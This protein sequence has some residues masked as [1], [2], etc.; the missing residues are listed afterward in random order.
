MS[1][2][3]DPKWTTDVILPQAELFA[4]PDCGRVAT[5]A[6]DVMECLLSPTYYEARHIPEKLIFTCDNPACPRCDEVF[7]FSLSVVV[8]ATADKEMGDNDNE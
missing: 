6:D 1:F 4:C 5:N 8:S 7:T 2:D 3:P